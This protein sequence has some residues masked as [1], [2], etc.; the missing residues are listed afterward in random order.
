MLGRSVSRGRLVAGSALS[1]LIAGCAGSATPSPVPTPVAPTAAV[2]T[3]S[4]VALAGPGLVGPNPTTDSSGHIQVTVRADI[5][6]VSNGFTVN[7]G[8]I[9]TV[10][11]TLDPGNDAGCAYA[12]YLTTAK[13]GPTIQSVVD[14]APAGAAASGTA[15]WTISP[16]SYLLQEDES[17]LAA[18]VRAFSATIAG[19]K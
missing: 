16:G 1:L 17:T 10:D 8:G 15:T 7:A 12:L 9:F 6:G 4:S 14:Y 11:Y 19:P 13:D 18:C 5:H 3:P 2:A